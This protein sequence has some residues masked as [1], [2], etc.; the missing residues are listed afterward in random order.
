MYRIFC[1]SYNNYIKGFENYEKNEYRYKITKPFLLLVNYDEFEKQKQNLTE[2]YKQASDLIF[3]FKSRIDDYPKLK[4]FLWTLESRGF[5]DIKYS[6]VNTED[7]EE[8][9]KLTNMFL[10]LIYW[11]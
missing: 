9:T 7:L 2:I 1:E 3:Y 11:F 4:A 5:T 10:S 6:I 8:Q